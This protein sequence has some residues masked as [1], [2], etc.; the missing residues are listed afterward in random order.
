VEADLSKMSEPK[1]LFIGRVGG[2]VAPVL[3]RF[4]TL[5]PLSGQFQQLTAPLGTVGGHRGMI[6][7]RASSASKPA[8]TGSS[9]PGILRCRLV[10]ALGFGF[11][12]QPLPPPL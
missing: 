11:H 8:L 4:V 5:N 9:S 12:C 10:N 2:I 7:W 6:P 3:G 1:S